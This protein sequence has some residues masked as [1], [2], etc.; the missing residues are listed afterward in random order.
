MEATGI[1]GH[2]GTQ[3]ATAGRGR[4]GGG[5]FHHGSREKQPMV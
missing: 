4:A 2:G 1:Q 3:D 5:G